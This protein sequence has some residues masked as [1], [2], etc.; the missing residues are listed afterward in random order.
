MK[1]YNTNIRFQGRIF[2]L[3]K[4][5]IYIGY[6]YN[7]FVCW[8]KIIFPSLTRSANLSCTI[9]KYTL[10][11]DRERDSGTVWY[12]VNCIMMSEGAALLR[13]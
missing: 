12:C 8:R 10:V 2:G 6:K 1:E 5:V 3:T 13:H 7:V 9:F 4:V 11:V